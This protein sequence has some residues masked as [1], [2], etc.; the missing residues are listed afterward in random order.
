VGLRLDFDA[1]SVWLIAAMPDGP[2]PEKP[3]VGGD[4]ILVVF[5]ADRLRRIGFDG[6][7]VT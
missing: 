6:T 3:F 4:E 5:D 2:H 1:G 7:F